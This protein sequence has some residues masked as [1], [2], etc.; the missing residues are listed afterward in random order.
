MRMYLFSFVVLIAMLTPSAGW[1]KVIDGP[2][3]VAVV[4]QGP[5]RHVLLIVYNSGRTARRVNTRFAVHS[6]VYPVEFYVTLSDAKGKVYK[7]N[8]RMRIGASQSHE[9]LQPNEAR[10]RLFDL[11]R[12]GKLRP[13]QYTLNVSY[14]NGANNDPKRRSWQGSATRAHRG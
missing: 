2:I 11:N 13:G 1:S 7:M 8:Q 12:F 5:P 10:G 3:S 4:Q 6:H 9:V 14:Q